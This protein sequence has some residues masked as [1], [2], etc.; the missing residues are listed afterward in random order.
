VASGTRIMTKYR[1]AL[2]AAALMLFVRGADADTVAYSFTSA[3]TSAE[4]GYTLGFVFSVAAG[5]SIAVDSLGWFDSSGFGFTTSHE[6]GI[7][8][9][10]DDGLLISATLD[11]G[12]VD[13]LIDGFRFVSIVPLVLG[14][15]LYTIGGTVGSDPWDY[16]VA[17]STITGFTVDPSIGIAAGAAVFAVSPSLVFPS[18]VFGYTVYA[19]PN[20]EMATPEP[21]G[22][23]LSFCG[24]LLIA[25]ASVLLHPPSAR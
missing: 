5:T 10:T 7:F 4:T 15:G 22:L 25:A 24:M 16:G 1:L 11:A 9:D 21:G 14:P 2:T 8:E 3:P 6:V 12:A 23:A 17:P 18:S 13:P 19:G 20:F